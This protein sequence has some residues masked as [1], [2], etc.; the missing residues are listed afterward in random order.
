MKT[1]NFKT[2]ARHVCLDSRKRGDPGMA[3]FV[4]GNRQRSD[5]AA[6]QGIDAG[7]RSFLHG[8]WSWQLVA[9][10]LYPELSGSIAVQ[11]STGA[12]EPHWLPRH[13]ANTYNA[14][15]MA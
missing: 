15:Q 13:L 5:V 10:V 9:F 6:W 4:S 14:V 12:S 2:H 1:C 8:N 7:S 3:C 11:G